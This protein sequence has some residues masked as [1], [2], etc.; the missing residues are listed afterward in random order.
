M[1]RIRLSPTADLNTS[2]QGKVRA[3]TFIHCPGFN[4][5]GAKTKKKEELAGSRSPLC[6][7]STGRLVCG[8]FKLVF[9]AGRHEFFHETKTKWQAANDF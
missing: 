7:H 2:G 3:I 9:L 8:V 5:H 1:S 6:G 4:Q